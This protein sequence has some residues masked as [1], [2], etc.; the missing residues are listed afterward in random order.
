MDKCI[1]LLKKTPPGEDPEMDLLAVDGRNVFPVDEVDGIIRREFNKIKADED[2]SN[3]EFDE[4]TTKNY[5]YSLTASDNSTW[6][7]NV[8]VLNEQKQKIASVTEIAVELAEG[9]DFETATKIAE[10]IHDD[11]NRDLAE[12]ADKEWSL[13]DLHLAIGRAFKKLLYI[14]EN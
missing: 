7:F 14:P 2:F 12:T 13:D 3:L 10:K 6:E 11:V 9:M 4:S 5:Y 8:Y 1:I